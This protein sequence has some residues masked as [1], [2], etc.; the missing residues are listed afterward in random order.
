MGRLPTLEMGPLTSEVPESWYLYIDELLGAAQSQE[1]HWRSTRPASPTPGCVSPRAAH[2]HARVWEMS[3]Q[4][5]K[6]TSS[7]SINFI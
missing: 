2:S 6:G 1:G 5:G 3:L 4:I 7:W